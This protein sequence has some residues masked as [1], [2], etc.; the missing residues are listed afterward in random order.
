M[1][2]D[3]KNQFTMKCEPFYIHLSEF[4]IPDNYQENREERLDMR[5]SPTAIGYSLTS[6][7][8]AFE[9]KFIE[10]DKAIKLL[11][12]ILESI[13]SLKKWHGHL[14]NWYNIKTKQVMAPNFI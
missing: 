10:L 14:Y 6:I 13:D 7:V 1:S 4:L 11:G 8:S 2:V 5:T 3:Q 9:L 12:N